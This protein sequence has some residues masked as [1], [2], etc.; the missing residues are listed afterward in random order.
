MEKKTGRNG[1]GML[2]NQHTR[3]G[4]PVFLYILLVSVLLSISIIICWFYYQNDG[5]D[6]EK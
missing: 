1:Y 5:E 3:A 4:R 6:R 2:L